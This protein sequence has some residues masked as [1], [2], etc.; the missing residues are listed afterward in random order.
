MMIVN[1]PLESNI[2]DDAPSTDLEE[3]FDPLLTSSPLVAPSFSNTPVATSVNDVI[4]LTPPVPLA[5]CMGLEI[6]EISGG[7]VSVLW[8]DSLSWPKEPTLVS[9]YLEEA[10][11]KELCVDIMIGS[12]TPGIGLIDPI[13]N[14]PLDLTPA[15]SSLLPTTPSHLHAYHECQATLKVIISSLIHIVCT[16]RTCLEKPCGVSSLIMLLIFLWHLM[17]LRGH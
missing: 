9:P 6:G 3:L 11:F 1:L 13:C 17:S 7:G 12:T 2:V 5:Q 8:D 16:N 15:S 14:E 4:L 10:A